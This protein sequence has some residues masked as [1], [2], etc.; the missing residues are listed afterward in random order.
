M[1][2]L[3]LALT[4]EAGD[5]CKGVPGTT[6]D[7]ELLASTTGAAAGEG[8][9]IASDLR[10]EHGAGTWV[11]AVSR[12]GVF[13]EVLAA[14]TSL[15]V[16]TKKEAVAVSSPV[17]TAPVHESHSGELYTTWTLHVPL[18]AEL[19]AGLERGRVEQIS[20]HLPGGE[21]GWVLEKRVTKPLKKAA[22][23]YATWL[24]QGA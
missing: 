15:L 24:V 19:L 1:T 21:L 11:L 13:D 7:V 4:A 9:W 8:S 17:D 16:L 20:G 5:P 6:P 3:L 2:L 23:C 22:G 14:D 10:W 12:L 18:T